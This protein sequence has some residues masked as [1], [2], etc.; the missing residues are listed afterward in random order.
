VQFFIARAAA[1]LPSFSLTSRNSPAIAHI[2][3]QLDGIPLALELAAARVQVLTV[4]Q[5]AARLDDRLHLLAGSTRTVPPRHQT[6][7]ATLDWSHA[8][9]SE[10]EQTLFR[11]LAVFVGGWTVEGAESVC[12][13]DG[14]E[15]SDVVDVLSR[16]V[17]KSLVTAEP[18]DET[19]RFRML[20]TIRQYAGDRL[21]DSGENDSLRTHHLDFNLRLAEDAYFHLWGADQ[22]AWFSRLETEYPNLRAALEW[23][24]TS[25]QVMAGLRLAGA[26]GYFW[27]TRLYVSEAR[28][29][30]GRL[31]AAPSGQ[32]RKDD[33]AAVRA[34]ALL[35]LGVIEWQDYAAAYPRL[36]ES[37]RLFQLVGDRQ[38]QAEALLGMGLST[39]YMGRHAEARS[40][41]ERSLTEF[42]A[43][44]SRQHIGKVFN[45]LGEIAREEG[46]Y[47]PAEA[48][49]LKGL[50]AAEQ[51]GNEW[52]MGCLVS[53]LGF[54]ARHQG[55]H[56]LARA[57]FRDSLA[58][59][60]KTK[61][62]DLVSESLI[63]LAGMIAEAGDPGRSASILGV[64]DHEFISLDVELD[65][66]DKTELEHTLAMVR[67]QMDA[68]A[69]AA[70]WAAGYAMTLEQ[71]IE[72]ALEEI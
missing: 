67:S 65:P 22:R 47:P 23:S 27:Y 10:A 43:L 39:T 70:A 66:A 34:R 51:M 59:G 8:L 1:V 61:D 32:A 11:R 9:L 63:G 72:F 16:L 54:V 14:L 13:G 38:G 69:F 25:G 20:E 5:I 4:E 19:P 17:D 68:P 64:I 24:D 15:E 26:L 55:D 33:S 28:L 30:F 7:R 46:D 41:L 45:V 37:L 53:N 49:Y 21:L 12:A 58:L 2:C 71:A 56:D 6:L 42:E 50:A 57:R 44:G 40:L 31:L 36:E 18:G 48:F 3:H 29:W 60:Q 62:R 35:W 52:Q